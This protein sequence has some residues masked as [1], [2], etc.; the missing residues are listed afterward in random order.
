MRG[1]EAY[2]YNSLAG[3]EPSYYI[4][5]AGKEPQFKT[6]RDG[7]GAVRNRPPIYE[8]TNQDTE[9]LRVPFFMDMFAKNARFF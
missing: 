4:I 6:T 2:K 1:K 3:H 5:E 8:G 7:C 9:Q